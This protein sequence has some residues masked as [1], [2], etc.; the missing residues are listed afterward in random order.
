M[1]TARIRRSRI[2]L[3]VQ[4]TTHES[5][6][7]ELVS[8]HQFIHSSIH[9]P[10]HHLPIQTLHALIHRS[11]IHAYIQNTCI[12][13]SMNPSV[14]PQCTDPPSMHPLI[15]PST[16]HP[17]TFTRPRNCPHATLKK[18]HIH[19]RV[20]SG[21]ERFS[22]YWFQK[23]VCNTTGGKRLRNFSSRN[24]AVHP[25]STLCEQRA[26]EGVWVVAY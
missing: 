5:I 24:T 20:F 23:N 25:R 15:P 16:I 8:I 17:S 12:H 4:R 26:Q 11:S 13:L 6:H 10:H 22:R 3:R 1:W 19:T 21:F 7:Y 14:H 18:I 2:H 9:H